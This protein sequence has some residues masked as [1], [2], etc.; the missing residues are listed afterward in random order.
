MENREEIEELLQ[1]ALLTKTIL[2]KING[3][4]Q[5]SEMLLRRCPRTSSSANGMNIKTANDWMAR[6]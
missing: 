5:T 1:E 6:E 3:V 4:P 2:Y